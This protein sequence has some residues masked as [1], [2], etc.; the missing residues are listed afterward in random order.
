MPKTWAHNLAVSLAKVIPRLTRVDVSVAQG[1]LLFTSGET[2][3]KNILVKHGSAAND[4]SLAW[5]ILRLTSVD[6]SIALGILMLVW[7]E[8]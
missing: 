3:H 7:E 2:Q 6:V 8:N 5:V 4:V 1:I